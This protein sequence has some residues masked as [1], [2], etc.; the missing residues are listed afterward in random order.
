M[1]SLDFVLDIAENLRKQ[2]IDYAI[3][4]IQK[5]GPKTKGKVHLF[6]QISDE[7]SVKYA[8]QGFLEL[9][10]TITDLSKKY[11]KEKGKNDKGGSK[12]GPKGGKNDK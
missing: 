9:G 1:P 12:D 10:K 3:I 5:G 6:Y 11:D 4:S 2:N 8:A 7:E